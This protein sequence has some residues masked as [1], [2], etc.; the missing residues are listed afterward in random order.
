[1][2]DSVLTRQQDNVLIITMNRPEV[3]NAINRD[4]A[5]RLADAFDELDAQDELAVGILTGSGSDFCAGM[6]LKAFSQGERP[7]SRGRGLGGL[8]QQPPRKPLIAAVEGHAVA[9]GFEM[10][11][12][13]DLLV[14]SET[15]RFGLPEV[16]RGLVAAG[17]GM[18]RLPRR[19]PYYQAM[20]ML[21]TGDVLPV[22]ELGHSGLVNQVTPAGQALDGAIVL[23]ARIARNAP[24]AVQ[25]TKRITT[26]ALDWEQVSAFSRQ[27]EFTEPVLSSADAL[28]GARA[29]VE[30][31]EPRWQGR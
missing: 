1:M 9:G 29:F 10:A 6:D 7:E 24:L 26:A 18:L 8:A 15:A 3:R 22:A 25:A 23:G 16:K 12:S 19:L 17:G 2:S 4:M 13:C 21:L 30:R 11:L 27:E 14:A 5:D 31:R 20:L 28:E